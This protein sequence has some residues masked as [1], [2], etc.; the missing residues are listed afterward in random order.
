MVRQEPNVA[1]HAA[2]ASQLQLRAQEVL[3]AQQL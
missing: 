3:S 1:V 2:E